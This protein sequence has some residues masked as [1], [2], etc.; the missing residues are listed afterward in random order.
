M[1]GRGIDTA[2]VDGDRRFRLVIHPAREA[3]RI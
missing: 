1:V 3:A 2:R